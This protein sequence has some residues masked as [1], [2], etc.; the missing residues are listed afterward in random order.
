LA[1]RHS[2]NV[3]LILLELLISA[4]QQAASSIPRANPVLLSSGHF[5]PFVGCMAASG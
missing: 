5:A 2:Q 3:A 4:R 1:L